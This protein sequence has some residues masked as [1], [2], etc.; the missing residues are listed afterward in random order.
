MSSIDLI[1]K[2]TLKSFKNVLFLEFYVS[3]L[4]WK[5][6]ENL[7]GIIYSDRLKL[8]TEVPNVG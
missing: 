2:M 1:P 3:D 5:N 6:L 8:D 7:L 4:T